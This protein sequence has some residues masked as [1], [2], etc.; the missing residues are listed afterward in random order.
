MYILTF[1]VM[2]FVRW[3]MAAQKTA[4]QRNLTATSHCYDAFVIKHVAPLTG[5]DCESKSRPRMDNLIELE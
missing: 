1:S 4:R 3:D 2:S 5:R